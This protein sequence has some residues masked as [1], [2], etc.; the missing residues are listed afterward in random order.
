[1]IFKD[2]IFK[3][4]EV[5]KLDP[6]DVDQLADLIVTKLCGKSSIM[7]IEENRNLLKKFII[8]VSKTV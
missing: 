3:D 8:E 6:K 2:E 5:E 7:S 1:M 4:E